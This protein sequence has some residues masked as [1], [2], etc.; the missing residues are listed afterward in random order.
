MIQKSGFDIH[1]SGPKNLIELSDE[2]TLPWWFIIRG[3]GSESSF[4]SCPS[5]LRKKTF[6]G[7]FK[8][9]MSWTQKKSRRWFYD[10]IAWLWTENSQPQ[11]VHNSMKKDFNT[12]DKEAEY[13]I[14]LNHLYVGGWGKPVAHLFKMISRFIIWPF[15][16]RS[17][18]VTQVRGQPFATL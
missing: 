3:F 16:V 6:W 17:F 18:I 2:F 14:V 9:K 7:K 10:P 1:A 4:S 8:K 15:K 12:G 13:E 5:S 11:G